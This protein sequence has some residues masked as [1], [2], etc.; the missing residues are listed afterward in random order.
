MEKVLITGMSGG[1]ANLLAAK[2]ATKFTIV[3]VDFRK[4]PGVWP[5][6]GEF[7]HLDYTKRSFGDIFHKHKFKAVIH[8]GRIGN[9]TEKFYKRYN[10]N[11]LGTANILN[12]CTKHQVE[13]VL[14]FSTFHIYGAHQYNPVNIDEEAPL[15]AGQIF[16]EIIDAVELDNLATSYFW[17]NRNARTIIL[18]P[19]NIIGRDIKNTMS[20]YFRRSYVP[21]L[22][23]F[24][25]MQQYIHQ[26]DI[27]NAI[28]LAI[29]NEN[30][31]GVYNITGG[32]AI[33][34][35]AAIKIA[36]QKGVA[37]PHHLAYSLVHRLAYFGLGFPHHLLDY[38]RYPVII[39]DQKFR[40][41][42][43]FTNL[44]NIKETIAQL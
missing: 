32:E 17:K 34:V 31:H 19:C 10:L 3:G 43:G 8:L 22:M 28:I 14:I 36:Q 38:F 5:Y 16:P 24:N 6:Q 26:E 29:E 30:I 25:P 33:P 12:L 20:N 42:T 40:D 39:S 18:R 4:Y 7:I 2:L 23:G 1:L 44:H 13:T 35:K 9:P 37:V 15:R 21:Y 41:V 27:T 11:V